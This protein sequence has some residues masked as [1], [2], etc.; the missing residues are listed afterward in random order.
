VK[1]RRRISIADIFAGIVIPLVEHSALGLGLDVATTEKEKSNP[2]SLAFVEKV[3]NDFVERLLLRWKTND[4]AVTRAIIEA[5]LMLIA[6]RRVRKLC[7]DATSERFFAADLKK[8]LGPMVPTDLIVASENHTYLGE[9]MTFKVYLGNLLVNTMED[10]HFAMAD[11]VWIKDDFRL[12][13]RDRGTFNAELDSAGNHADTFDGSKLAL[14]AIIGPGGPAAASAA[15][16]GTFGGKASSAG[17]KNPFAALH[18][19]TG[20]MNNA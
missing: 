13:K 18:R 16:V 8:A 15:Q 10:G 7:I 2:S 19:R 9:E 4:P 1:P 17:W 3:G 14:H 5:V 6:P 20:G 11:E 12:V